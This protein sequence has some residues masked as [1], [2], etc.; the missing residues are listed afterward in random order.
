MGSNAIAL[1][2]L[3]SALL[4]LATAAWSLEGCPCDQ[5][6]DARSECPS[7]FLCSGAYAPG[8]LYQERG[9]RRWWRPAGLAAA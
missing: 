3:T 1:V 5:I 8:K 6:P 4:D 9:A 7:S 2:P